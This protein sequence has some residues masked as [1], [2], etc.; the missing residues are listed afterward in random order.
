MENANIIRTQAERMTKI[1]RQ[2]L[3]FA[4][5]RTHETVLL[6]LRDIVGE[7]VEMLSSFAKKHGTLLASVQSD[8]SFW[9]KA[10]RG[11]IQ[12]VLTNL[13]VNAVQATGSGG[14]VTIACRRTITQPP[15]GVEGHDGEYLCIDVRDEGEG[16]SEENVGH[17]FDPFFTTK[18]VGEGTGLGLSIAYGII[19]EHGG[20]IDVKSERGRG[21]CFSVY[22]PP[23]QDA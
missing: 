17:L 4:R 16:V 22:L 2:L 18:D 12:Q 20:W 3:D 21:S 19:R 11:Q 15:E 8:E 13:I 9:T 7:A 1:I 10:D 5:Q 14:E 6:D 23:E